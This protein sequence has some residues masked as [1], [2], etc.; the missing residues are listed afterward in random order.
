MTIQKHDESSVVVSLDWD[1]IE[2]CNRIAASRT[3]DCRKNATANNFGLKGSINDLLKLDFQGAM[4][5]Y[6]V[7]RELNLYWSGLGG[8]RQPDVGF[9]IEVKSVVGYDRR[10]LITDKTPKAADIA[11]LVRIISAQSVLIDGW[12][13]IQECK[14]PAYVETYREGGGGYF[15]P[16]EKL[17]PISELKEIVHSRREDRHKCIASKVQMCDIHSNESGLAH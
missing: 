15:V 3:F 4:A 6:A 9:C 16:N 1:E 7:S 14:N 17:R 5:E 11:V 8:P 2:F 10:L 13:Y 12:A